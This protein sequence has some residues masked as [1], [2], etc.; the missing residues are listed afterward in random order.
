MDNDLINQ[1]VVKM[2]TEEVVEDHACYDPGRCLSNVASSVNLHGQ[3]LQRLE[4][5]FQHPKGMLNDY[6][7]T[8]M[9][10]VEAHLIPLSILVAW[11]DS[12][13]DHICSIAKNILVALEEVIWS[14]VQVCLL[15]HIC[16]MH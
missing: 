3:V 10:S 12:P 9:E 16:I 15:V 4:L 8:T 11:N 7:S 6:S 5:E 13:G 2:E 14:D 1:L